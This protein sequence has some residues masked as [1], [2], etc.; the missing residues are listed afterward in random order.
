MS[1]RQQERFAR[2]QVQ[3][4]AKGTRAE[5]LKQAF[6]K[7]CQQQLRDARL[8]LRM[9]KRMGSGPII[10]SDMQSAVSSVMQSAMTGRQPTCSR[11]MPV[12]HHFHR[13]DEHTSLDTCEDDEGD[14]D[15]D[16]LRITEEEQQALIELWDEIAAELL[17]EATALAEEEE[18][19]EAAQLATAVQ[20]YE[21]PPVVCPICMKVALE[22]HK[23]L[24]YCKCGFQLNMQNDNTSLAKFGEMIQQT[25][26]QHS[27]SGCPG[28]VTFALT[29]LGS[30]AAV[31]LASCETCDAF[32][33]V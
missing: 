28:Q 14:E 7:R 25:V 5:Q 16:A 20:D 1:S 4:G 26:A 12:R 30:P 24:I 9:Q 8:Q 29:T 21:Q 23:C 3:I 33:V 17:A 22:Q 31:L 18:A 32:E 6:K 13:A 2:R 10:A 11:T 15:I 19:H 27:A